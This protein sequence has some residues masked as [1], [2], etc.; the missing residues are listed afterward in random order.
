[1]AGEAGYTFQNSLWDIIG[2]RNLENMAYNSM[3]KQT[4]G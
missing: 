3:R 2:Y 4:K 1:M